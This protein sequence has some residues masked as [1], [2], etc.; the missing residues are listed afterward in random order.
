MLLHGYRHS[1]KSVQV[2]A[3]GIIYHNHVPHL[4]SHHSLLANVSLLALVYLLF[5]TWD[6]NEAAEA[7][8]KYKRPLVTLV[9][10]NR[11]LTIAV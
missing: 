8:R 9:A 3:T 4:Q 10:D 11:D 5:L 1:F 7:E 6:W 2:V